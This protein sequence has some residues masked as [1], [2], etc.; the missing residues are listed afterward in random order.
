MDRRD[1]LLPLL[2][3]RRLAW[4]SDGAG[5]SRLR[6]LDDEA[7][8]RARAWSRDLLDRLVA[9]GGPEG[10]ALRARVEASGALVEAEWLRRG[11]T[12]RVAARDLWAEADEGAHCPLCRKWVRRYWH[13][14]NASMARGLAWLALAARRPEVADPEG[15]VHVPTHGPRWLVRTNQH[16]SLRLWGLAERRAP[17]E[18]AR[19]KCSGWWRPT[20]RGFAFVDG[21][22]EVE[23]RVLTYN[24]EVVARGVETLRFVDVLDVAFDYAELMGTPGALPVG[25]EREP[26]NTDEEDNR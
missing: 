1:D 18:E 20:A 26:F 11:P 23:D 21:L 12:L 5:P 7:V 3:E 4:L 19:V 6:A 8:E 22:V 15:W 14:L 2:D 25:E 9:V 17:D 10:D 24:G 16:A 13:R